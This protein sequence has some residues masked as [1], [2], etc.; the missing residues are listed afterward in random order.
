MTAATKQPEHRRIRPDTL[1]VSVTILLVANIIQRS[2]GFGR[3]ILF[4]RWLEPDELGAWDMAYSFLLL[5]APVVVLG[6]PG[7]FGRYLERF[8]QRGQLR[9]FLRRA[10][11][12]TIALTLVSCASIVLAAPQFSELIFGRPDA[13][14]LTIT[15]ALS[16]VAVILHHFLEALFAA[17]RKFS[18]VS[19][20][21]FCQSILFAVISLTLIWTWRF[22]AESI[23]IGYGAACLASVVGVLLWK[24]GAILAEAVHDDGVPHREFWPPLMRFAFWVWVIN[25]FSHLFGVIDRYMLVHYSGLDSAASL[26][27]V[28]NYHASRIIPVLFLSVS[29]LLAGAVMPY[30]SHDWENGAR[31]LVSDRLNTVLKFTSLVMLAGG[32]AV[33]WTAPLL[34]QIAFEGRYD[35]GLAV[36]PWTLTYCVWYSLLLVAQNYLWC[37]ERARLGV[38]PL[39]IGLS[40]NVA[41]DLAL[42]PSWGLFGA[43]VGTTAATAVATGLV[44]WINHYAGMQLQRG[45]VLLSLAPLALCG[46]AWTGSAMLLVVLACLPF[47]QTL[48]TPEERV[49]LVEFAGLYTKRWKTY[50]NR[51]AKPSEPSHA[52]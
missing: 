5:A 30:L 10:T 22:A 15:V 7:S 18:I 52:I 42:I 38:L 35:S 17:L 27:L 8:R 28:G 6:L 29:D 48:V 43:V 19:S 21:H 4:C 37:A 25:L 33:L 3:G 51:S 16:L 49:L 20:M 12:W 23:V 31:R 1:A 36:L 34:F 2:I 40:I 32:V 11:V 26:A 45:M 44:Y 14:T 24:G 47:S 41:I 39:V 46:G 13:T 50:W 9:T